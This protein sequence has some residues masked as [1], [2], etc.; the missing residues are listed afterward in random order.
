MR[1]GESKLSPKIDLKN[2]K[3][4]ISRSS[5]EFIFIKINTMLLPSGFFAV[6]RLSIQAP[7]RVLVI[8]FYIDKS[9]CPPP[10][11]VAQHVILYSTLFF[12]FFGTSNS[13]VRCSRVPASHRRSSNDIM[14]FIIIPYEKSRGIYHASTTMRYGYSVVTFFFFIFFFII[15]VIKRRICAGG[16]RRRRRRRCT[17]RVTRYTSARGKTCARR[18]H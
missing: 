15:V 5:I 7:V 18:T 9:T 4:T 16:R 17:G 6:T 8:I 1:G 13:E 11:T 12:F 3:K 10:V 14:T 2:E